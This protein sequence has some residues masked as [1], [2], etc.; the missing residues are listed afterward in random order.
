MGTIINTKK[1][2]NKIISEIMSDYQDYLQLKGHF[3][4]IH[5]FSENISEVRSNIS[6]RGK[7]AA[8]KY[9]L[10]PKQFRKGIKFDNQTACQKLELGNKIFFIYA[11]D[12]AKTNPLNRESTQIQTK[13]SLLNSGNKK[14]FRQ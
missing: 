2:G 8:T 14:D 10:I 5:L 12:K 11:V 1:K 9:F 4:K 13:Y 7:N 6:Q 3:D